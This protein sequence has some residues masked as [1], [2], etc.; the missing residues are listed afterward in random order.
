MISFDVELQWKLGSAKIKV[1][2]AR[3]G[4]SIEFATFVRVFDLGI[5]GEV[6]FVD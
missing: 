3:I 1:D 5:L 6:A 2:C 4:A